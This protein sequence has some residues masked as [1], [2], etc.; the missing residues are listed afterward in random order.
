MSIIFNRYEPTAGEI[1][2][3]ARLYEREP[4]DCGPLHALLVLRIRNKMLTAEY[5]ALAA[6][7]KRLETVKQQDLKDQLGE[8][9][10]AMKKANG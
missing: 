1:D 5:E 2:S 10:R 3:E 6:D 7:M 4:V 8:M 9:L